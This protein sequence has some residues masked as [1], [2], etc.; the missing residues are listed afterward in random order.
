CWTCPVPVHV[1]TLRTSERRGNAPR[2][3]ANEAA[4][5]T[6]PSGR[7]G[8]GVM[9]LH[10]HLLSLP[11][12]LDPVESEFAKDVWDVRCIPGA[13]YA[14]H[15]SNHLLNFTSIPTPFRH[16]VKRYLKFL[17]IQEQSQSHCTSQLRYIRQFLEF[18]VELRPNVRNLHQLNRNDI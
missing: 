9:S 8:A 16:V 14:A 12:Q 5:S 1:S 17:L 13:R 3:G 18:F 10:G 2:L 15:Q 11:S 7:E 4:T 6:E